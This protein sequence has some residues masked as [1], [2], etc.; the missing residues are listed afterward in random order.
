MESQ[1][2][3]D[4]SVA[5]PTDLTKCP[6][7]GFFMGMLSQ[8]HDHITLVCEACHVSLSLPRAKWEQLTTRRKV[9]PMSPE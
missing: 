5:A 3:P 6:V 7:C 1:R 8:T 4:E 2:G 9:L